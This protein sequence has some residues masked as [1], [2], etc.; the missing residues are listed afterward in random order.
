ML[1]LKK[2]CVFFKSISLSLL[3]SLSLSFAALLSLSL[4]LSLSYYLSLSFYFISS[5][6]FS[7]LPSPYL[8]NYLTH[9]NSST[10]S[11]LTLSL[12]HVSNRAAEG[13]FAEDSTDCWV[14]KVPS[15]YSAASRLSVH[16]TIYT[17]TAM[18]LVIF[19]LL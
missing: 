6:Y 17:L 14:T 18:L 8:Y 1:V 16:V 19:S 12:Y 15:A 13:T 11:H 10:H 5:L 7:L 9:L 4:V 3:Y 2:V